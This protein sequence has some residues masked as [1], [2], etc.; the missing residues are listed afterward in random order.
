MTEPFYVL[1]FDGVICDSREE[2]MVTSFN[3]CRRLRGDHELDFDENSIPLK[4]RL[5]FRKYRF[6]ARTAQEFKLLWDLIR[7]EQ[8]IAANRLI[9]DQ[10]VADESELADYR[11]CFYDV[12]VE[13]RE[14]DLPSWLSANPIFGDVA[15]RAIRWMEAGRLAVVSAKDTDSILIIMHS[16]G[17]PLDPCVVRGMDEASDKGEFFGEIRTCHPDDRVVLIDDHIE[18]LMLAKPLGFEL[19]LA[20]WGYTAEEIISEAPR[21]GIQPISEAEL[22]AGV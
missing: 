3:A 12:R 2:C 18:N 10:V 19:C 14:R 16:N 15:A 13:W 9:R 8:A 6:L 7:S 5:L 22:L 1:D 4:D 11:R 20:T 21:Y 17:F